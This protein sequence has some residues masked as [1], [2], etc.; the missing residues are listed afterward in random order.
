MVKTISEKLAV[1]RLRRIY[2]MYIE[3][4]FLQSKI[5]KL[6]S[7]YSL[8]AGLNENARKKIAQLS[9]QLDILTYKINEFKIKLYGF[10]R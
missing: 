3:S 9:K 6:V 2:C 7:K 1:S 10:D 4:I 8:L 5:E